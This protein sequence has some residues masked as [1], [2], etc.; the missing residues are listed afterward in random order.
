M[1][2]NYYPPFVRD[3]LE[4]DEDLPG[5]PSDHKIVI[6]LPKTDSNSRMLPPRKLIKSLPITQSGMNA[7]DR[8]L[9][10]HKWHEVL[11][12]DDKDVKAHS[13]HDTIISKYEELFPEKN[14]LFL[15]LWISHG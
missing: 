12:T 6:I 4:C 1:K 3:P 15:A 13:F 5:E 10:T 8:F 14:L 7:L 11:S 9:T 2:E